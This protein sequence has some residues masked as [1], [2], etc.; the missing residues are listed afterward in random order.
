MSR[1]QRNPD[2]GSSGQREQTVMIGVPFKVLDACLRPV[3]HLSSLVAQNVFSHADIV[4]RASWLFLRAANSGA[5]RYSLRTT[6]VLGLRSGP[7]SR[8][9]QIHNTVHQ[10]HTLQHFQTWG[11][12]KNFSTG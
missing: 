11:H 5:E 6:V 12:E 9:P 2:P 4:G 10:P 8:K 7:P 3:C 1:D